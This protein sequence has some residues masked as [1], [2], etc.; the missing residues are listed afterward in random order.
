MRI[1]DWSS[2]VCSSDLVAG[3]STGQEALSL[4]MLV[5]KHASR[6]PGL[7]VQILA[8]DISSSV[9][10][11]AQYGLY[12]QMEVQRGLGVTDLLVWFEPAAEEWQASRALL[13]MIDYRVDHLLEPTVLTGAYQPILCR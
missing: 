1:R 11:R 5:R 6:W 13:E 3:G 4:A 2:D 10:A 12:N 8:T 9:I 7:R